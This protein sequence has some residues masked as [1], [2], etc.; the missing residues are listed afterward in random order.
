[1]SFGT[2]WQSDNDD[3]GNRGSR[4]NFV[5]EFGNYGYT[6]ER[7]GAGW[8][9]DRI[10]RHPN[11]SLA[12]WH[13]GDPGVVPNVLDT[14]AG[15]PS[16]I[17]FYEGDLLGPAFRNQMI[18]AEPG[19]NIVRAYPMTRQGAG[20]EGSITPLLY[21]ARDKWFR[22][23][24][25]RAAPDGSLFVADWYDPGVGGHA[26]GDQAR[27]RVFRIA[28]PEHAYTVPDFD[29][30]TAA[31][32]AE[33]LKST[34][35]A[36]RY[37]AWTALHEMGNDAI[38]ALRQMYE[39]DNPRYRARALW[40]LSKVE[41]SDTKVIDE[42]LGDA[43][44][45]IRITALRAA[46]Q[47]DVP[48][49]PYVSRVVEDPSPAV[50]REA[51]IALRHHEGD[52]AADLWAQLAMQHTHSDSFY[53]EALGIGADRQWERFFDAWL[54]K[55]GDNW[56]SAAGREIVWRSRTP[57]ALPLLGKVIA[58]P[59]TSPDVLPRYFRALDFHEP[60]ARRPI[61]V[62]LLTVT[63]DRADAITSLALRQIGPV[64]LEQNPTVKQGVER[65]LEQ[66]EAAAALRIIQQFNL[67]DRA[68]RLVGI[69]VGHPQQQLGV[70][71]ARLLLDWDQR[72]L[73]EQ[74]LSDDE[75]A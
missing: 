5:M 8:N 24:A 59:A 30:T 12:H 75:V 69:V 44:A 38:P 71:S 27:G 73:I 46:R 70:Q 57:R 68:D 1:D 10:N 62:S 45:D 28:P 14:G 25:V 66:A 18:H 4:I 36:V 37:L 42:A 40:L 7:T 55:V 21:G 32:A 3:D 16:G 9:T 33:A 74:R 50:R 53:L 6:D 23:V 31:G 51:L 13:H 17:T 19:K 52:E 43:D 49:L 47:L 11:T 67:R 35:Q 22:P 34:T 72:T 56:N 60:E 20:Y 61:L 54:A 48:I 65:A 64:D 29:F 26:K 2:V 15:S 63:G 41:G 58:D 39:S